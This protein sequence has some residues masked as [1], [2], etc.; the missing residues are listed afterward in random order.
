MKF[1]ILNILTIIFVI[2]KL[3]GVIDWSWGLVLL[4]TWG[5]LLALGIFMAVVGIAATVTE[6]NRPTTRTRR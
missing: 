2:A 6:L 5:P 3:S 4:P 1:G